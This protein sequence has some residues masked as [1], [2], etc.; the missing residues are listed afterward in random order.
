MF[1]PT[2]F[3]LSAEEAGLYNPFILYFVKFLEQNGH[4]LWELDYLVARNQS[5][6]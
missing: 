3:F 4:L 6:I 2:F 5:K 1:I